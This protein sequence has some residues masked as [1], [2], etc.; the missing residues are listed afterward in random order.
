MLDRH[1][2]AKPANLSEV[3]PSCGLKKQPD[4]AAVAQ[5]PVVAH[6]CPCLVSAIGTVVG[7]RRPML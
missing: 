1:S 6:V 3:R 2:F 4:G 7:D 5:L